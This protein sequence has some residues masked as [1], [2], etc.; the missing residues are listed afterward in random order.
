MRLTILKALLVMSSNAL[1]SECFDHDYQSNHRDKI[2]QLI[3]ESKFCHSDSDCKLI[4]LGCPFG[5]G[6]AINL[7]SVEKTLSITDSYHN[8][9]CSQ[10]KHK[11]RNVTEALCVN[12]KCIAK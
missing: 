4:V 5:C 1:A 8:Q 6:T 12:N 11:C 3:S 10:C 2:Y 7:E 9:S